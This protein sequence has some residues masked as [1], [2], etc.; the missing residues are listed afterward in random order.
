MNF[1]SFYKTQRKEQQQQKLYLKKKVVCVHK[2]YTL[3]FSM[4]SLCP[5]A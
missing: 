4:I 2:N 1:F 3:T 5:E